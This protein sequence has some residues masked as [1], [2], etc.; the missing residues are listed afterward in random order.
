ME[1]ASAEIAGDVSMTQPSML[2]L[3]RQRTHSSPGRRER[4]LS[5]WLGFD[6]QNRVLPSSRATR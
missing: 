5:P 2:K 3:R 6:G 1:A 4:R